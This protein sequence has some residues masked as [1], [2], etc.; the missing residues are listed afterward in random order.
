M[1]Q[2][3]QPIH[4]KLSSGIHPRKVN[5]YYIFVINVGGVR[6]SGMILS[7]NIKNEA[8]F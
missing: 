6:E 1:Y 5:I 7:L 8:F 4:A 3:A 2:G